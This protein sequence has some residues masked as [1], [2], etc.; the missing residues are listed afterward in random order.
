MKSPLVA[1]DTEPLAI[2][3]LTATRYHSICARFMSVGPLSISIVTTVP[4]RLGTVVYCP[5]D[6]PEDVFEVAFVPDMQLRELDGWRLWGIERAAMRSCWSR[7][8]VHEVSKQSVRLA[9]SSSECDPGWWLSQANY[10]S[11]RLSVTSDFNNY[12]L[13]GDIW[14]DLEISESGAD[15]PPGFLFVCATEDFQIGPNSIRPPDCP[16]YWSLD[17]LGDR[18]LSADEAIALG[19]PTFKLTTNFSG[20]SWE[21]SIYDRLRQFHQAK[22]F[23]PYTQ[24]LA[25]DLGYPLFEFSSGGDPVFAHV[26]PGG[27]ISFFSISAGH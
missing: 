16:A 24:D 13:V 23:D 15:A 12:L 10:I 14:F 25:R 22:G 9:G 1:L 18:R 27:G 7:F 8:E 21:N 20:W 5:A 3:A 19:F 11:S 2:D 26:I 6:H 17:P 4:V